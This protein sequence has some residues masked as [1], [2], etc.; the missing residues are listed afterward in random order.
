MKRI[1]LIIFLIFTIAI[2]F[3][4]VFG[5]PEYQI[6]KENEERMRIRKEELGKANPKLLAEFEKNMETLEQKTK[7]TPDD[8]TYWFELGTNK[9]QVGDYEGA[10]EALKKAAQLDLVSTNALTNLGV[11]YQ[12]VAKYQ[13]A[14][15]AFKEI[16]KRHPNLPD[17]YIRLAELYRP[18]NYKDKAEEEKVLLAALSVMEKNSILLLTLAEYYDRGK[19]YDQALTTYKRLLTLNPPN[20]GAIE[21]E[22]ARLE[23]LAI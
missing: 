8:S 1:S 15:E 9:Y 22:I 10:E 16:V 2:V 4:L 7:E 3:A 13:K 23:K 18:G 19:F 6:T 21:E 11:L 12:D 14:E 20:K 17:G 5:L